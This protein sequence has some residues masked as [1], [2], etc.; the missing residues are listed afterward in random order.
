[1]TSNLGPFM[2]FKKE[3]STQAFTILRISILLFTY[4]VFGIT[5]KLKRNL[6]KSSHSKRIKEE[7]ILIIMLFF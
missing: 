4:V 3:R 7:M 6:I 2:A 5:E 1:M